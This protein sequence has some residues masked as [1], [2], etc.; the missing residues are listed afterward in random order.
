MPARTVADFISG[1]ID[2]RS[3]IR[4]ATDRIALELDRKA[5]GARVPDAK[6]QL[7]LKQYTEQAW[8]V[9]EPAVEFVHGW[10]LDAIC[11]HLE[12]VQLGQIK[13]LVINVPPRHAKSLEAGVFWFSHTWTYAPWMRFLYSSYAQ[14]LTTRDS[15]KSRRLI[16]S[17]WYQR[18]WGHMFTLTSD[19]NQKTR[20]ENNKTGYRLATS[21]KGSNTGEGGQIIVVDDP[22]NAKER[23]STVKREEV[24]EWWDQVMSSRLDD[25]KTGHKVIIMQ[26]LHEQDLSGHVLKGSDYEHLKLPAQ[27]HAK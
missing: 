21:V 4:F 19:Q 17:M 1:P 12:A 16:E 25:Q 20:F 6:P 22:L 23:H 15:V 7:S 3:P 9:V 11:E 26:R 8:H 2:I 10:H 13:N 5:V 18:H 14:N 27:H 24:L